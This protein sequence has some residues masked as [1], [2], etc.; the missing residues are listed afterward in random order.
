MAIR[1][2]GGRGR[3]M[4]GRMR[5]GKGRIAQPKIVV[6]NSGPYGPFLDILLAGAGVSCDTAIRVVRLGPRGTR[7]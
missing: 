4:L 3:G 7:A 6:Q 2:G 1:K 5:R